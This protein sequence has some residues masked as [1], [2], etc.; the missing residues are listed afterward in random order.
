MI[1]TITS[2]ITLKLTGNGLSNKVSHLPK[3]ESTFRNFQPSTSVS[4]ANSSIEH[5]AAA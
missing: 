4:K 1:S 2:L 3:R 5:P